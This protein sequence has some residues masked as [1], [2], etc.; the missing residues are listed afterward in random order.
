MYSFRTLLVKRSFL[1][2]LEEGES[3]CGA[4]AP[5]TSSFEETESTFAVSSFDSGFSSVFRVSLESDFED[6]ALDPSS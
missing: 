5:E 2:L 6:R 3:G 4:L 1:P